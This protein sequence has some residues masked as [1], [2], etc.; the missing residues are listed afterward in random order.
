MAADNPAFPSA[1][2]LQYFD[3]LMAWLRKEDAA[4]SGFL[5]GALDLDNLAVAG[6]SRGGKLAALL[7]AGEALE[8]VLAC[9]VLTTWR[10]GI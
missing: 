2:Q 7:Y 3:P 9:D 4:S 8:A 1:V 10:S 6:H 5:H